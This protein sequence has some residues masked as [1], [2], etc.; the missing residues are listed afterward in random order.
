MVCDY[1]K[2]CQFPR[3]NHALISSK[4]FENARSPFASELADP[5]IQLRSLALIPQGINNST[6]PQ[7]KAVFECIL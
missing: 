7:K 1:Q 5:R 3:G 4:E 2:D 6:Q